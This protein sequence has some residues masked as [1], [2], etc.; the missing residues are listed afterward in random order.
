MTELMERRTFLKR[1]GYFLGGIL[2][3]RVKN[4][5]KLFESRKTDRTSLREAKYY[6]RADKLVG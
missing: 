4:S 6:T 3:F 5:L 2:L 1:A